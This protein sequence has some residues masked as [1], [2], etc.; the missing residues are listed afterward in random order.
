MK[1][2]KLQRIAEII[3][4]E[5][6]VANPAQPNRRMRR[7]QKLERRA[8]RPAARE[9]RGQGVGAQRELAHIG[10]ADKPA[11]RVRLKREHID[12]VLIAQSAGQV[13]GSWVHEV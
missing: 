12:D 2:E 10:D 1:Q 3:M 4:M 11:C 7:D 13:G 6:I 9:R 5:L 8:H